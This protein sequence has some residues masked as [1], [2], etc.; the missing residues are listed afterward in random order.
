MK[1]YLE[2]ASKSSN[3]PC[4]KNPKYQET[5]F[6]KRIKVWKNLKQIVAQQKSQ[7]TSEVS[8]KQCSSYGLIWFIL[9]K[10]LLESTRSPGAQNKDLFRETNL[11]I[12]EKYNFATY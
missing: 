12:L 10:A 8:C 1:L 3:Y 2:E 4:F 9:H 5:G 11:F 6:A 7:S